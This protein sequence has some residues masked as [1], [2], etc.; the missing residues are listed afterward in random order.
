MDVGRL[1]ILL[2]IA[3]KSEEGRLPKIG[4]GR[5]EDIL[6]LEELQVLLLVVASS[7]NCQDL[8][9]SSNCRS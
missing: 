4:I 9:T 7:L 2:Q 1:Y 5:L 6:R 3:I 8:T